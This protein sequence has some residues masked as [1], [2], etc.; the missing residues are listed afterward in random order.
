VTLIIRIH[1]NQPLASNT[2]VEIE[3]DGFRAVGDVGL[4]PP[5]AVAQL[6]RWL[7][8]NPQ[9]QVVTAAGRASLNAVD[10][11]NAVQ[12]IVE[13]D[14]L[15]PVLWED[16]RRRGPLRGRPIIRTAPAEATR[17]LVP[18]DLPVD[19]LVAAFGEHAAPARDQRLF[20]YFRT[21]WT[22]GA[23]AETL[24]RLCNG[25]TFD[26]IHL[27]SAGPPLDHEELAALTAG[28][29]PRLLVLEVVGGELGP[30]LD[31]AHRA[32]RPDGPSILVIG[33]ESR[34]RAAAETGKHVQQLYLSAVHNESLDYALAMVQ[35]SAAPVLALLRH[36]G[37][38]HILRISAVAQSLLTAVTDYHAAGSQLLASLEHRS[39]TAERVRDPRLGTVRQAI[40]QLHQWQRRPLDYTREAGAWMPLAEATQK[41][42]E[43]TANL[44]DVTDVQRVVN[45][46]FA[47]GERAVPA[48][49]ALQADHPYDLKVHIGLPV[50]ESIVGDGAGF[51][52]RELAFVS[53]D[54]IKV[55]VVVFSRDLVFPQRQHTLRLPPPPADSRVLSIPLRTPAALGEAT[56]RVGI[57]FRHQLLQSQRITVT[58]RDAS[59]APGR[60]VAETDFVLSGSLGNLDHLEARTVTFLMNDDVGGDHTLAVV[61][62]GPPRSFTLTDARMR[63]TSA[64]SRRALQEVCS[65]LRDGVPDEYRFGSDNQGRPDRLLDDVRELAR[66]GYQLYTDLVTGQDWE[67]QDE[68]QA[69]LQGAAT[70]QV[71]ATRSATLV[72]PWAL[73]YD[74]PLDL[75]ARHTLCEEFRR[76]LTSGAPPGWLDR[77]RCFDSQCASTQDATVICPSGFWGFRHIIEQPLSTHRQA[78]A[79]SE[80]VIQDVP[81]TIT[82]IGSANLLMAVSEDLARLT[83]HRADVEALAHYRTEVRSDRIDIG[84]SLQRTDLQVVYFYCHGG[85]QDLQ[86]WL[87]VGRQQR[88][89]PADLTRWHIRWPTSHPLVFING[90]RT[91]GVTPDDLTSFLRSLSY[92][93]ASGVIGVEITIPEE[94]AQRF[95]I[96]F[97]GPFGDGAPVGE[98]VRSARRH[99]LEKANPLGLAYT[100]YCVADLRLDPFRN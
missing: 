30:V 44:P 10:S 66:V 52:D 97:L 7:T 59:G 92:S 11:L 12:L 74:K 64:L 48:S 35:S 47:E 15:F 4:D 79:A 46:W 17:A 43:V 70:I 94:L 68:L 55:D 95:A 23:T 58:I 33:S 99:L 73:V 24:K 8:S 81:R 26:I 18:V 83:D 71:A 19:L 90:C 31:V 60:Q 85:R 62:G 84:E 88:L 53:D 61:G 87:G 93:R 89:Y 67:F 69:T 1:R 86:V 27:R 2:T 75:D 16:L 25:A 29:Q 37:G 22:S 63:S 54:G 42:E 14:S 56:A 65:T 13:E 20:R 50:V 91:V 40:E 77:L 78:H 76:G 3:H 38:E 51:P 100:P 49:S 98:L 80:P 57:Y 21:T 32:L 39:S 41:F 28:S 45:L 5:T 72:F 34:D 82:T 6:S 36:T 96:D 9:R